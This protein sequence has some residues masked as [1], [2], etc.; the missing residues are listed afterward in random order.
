MVDVPS[1]IMPYQQYFEST[2]NLKQ[3][4]EMNEKR[5]EKRTLTRESDVK[6]TKKAKAQ[7][8]ANTST[9]DIGSIH[10]DHTYAKTPSSDHVSEGTLA[11]NRSS[12]GTQTDVTL[13]NVQQWED[14]QEELIRLR[15][16]NEELRQNLQDKPTIKRELFMEDVLKSDESVRFYT[17]V[18]SLSCLQM[19]S[20]LLRPEAEKLKYWDRNKGK[21]MAYQTSGKKNRDRINAEIVHFYA[22]KIQKMH[23]QNFNASWDAGR[24]FVLDH[25]IL[26]KT[27]RS[28]VEISRPQSEVEISWPPYWNE[29]RRRL[30]TILKH[31]GVLHAYPPF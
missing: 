28:E 15:K 21:T 22:E 29:Q 3:R 6:T 23:F 17:G 20:E 8:A 25:F 4:R 18:P 2:T 16:E 1:A 9:A 31:P 11:K 24:L 26:N 13:L 10:N 19:L 12:T 5:A 14:D 30:G 7:S 27:K